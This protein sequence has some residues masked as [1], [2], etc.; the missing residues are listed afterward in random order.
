[1]NLSPF[2]WAGSKAKLI[3]IIYNY[4]NQL[5][6]NSNEYCE[7]FIGGGSVALFIAEKY[8]KIQLY[9]CDKDEWVSSFWS[10]ILDYDKL[11]KLLQLIQQQPT[12]DLFYKLRYEEPIDDIEKAYRVIFFNRCCF[13]GIVDRKVG[14]IGGYDQKSKYKIDCRYNFNKLKEKIIKCHHLLKNRTI[15]DNK[16]FINYELIKTDI[17]CYIDPPYIKAG[18]SLYYEKMNMKDHNELAKILNNRNNWILSY[19]DCNIIRDLYNKYTII[20]LSAKYCIN[21]KK[22]NWTNKNELIIF[23]LTKS[24]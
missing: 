24:L 17:P 2:R 6:E 8:P 21:G 14:P 22:N 19:D 1:M 18:D 12:I 7:P 20:D 5:L 16:D 10:V 3:N 15:V 4:L 9:L 23:N 11:N 13:S